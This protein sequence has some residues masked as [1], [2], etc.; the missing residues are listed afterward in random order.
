MRER[1]EV[2]PSGY[3]LHWP[4]VDEDLSIDGLTGVRHACALVGAEA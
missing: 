3:G 1:I 2:S 4:E